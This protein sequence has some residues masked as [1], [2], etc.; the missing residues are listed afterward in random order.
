M[1]FIKKIRENLGLSRYRM[2]YELEFAKTHGYTQFEEAK[3]AVSLEKLVKLW[4]LSG[5]SGNEFMKMI[6]QEVESKNQ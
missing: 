6:A 4:R 5:L 1:Y 3:K 2:A